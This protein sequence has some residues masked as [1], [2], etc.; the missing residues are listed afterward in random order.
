MA[1]ES[2]QHTSLTE[3]K[4]KWIRVELD[5]GKVLSAEGSQAAEIW[6]WLMAAESILCIHGGHYRGEPF[7]T[8]EPEK[9]R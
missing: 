7:T 1:T 5:N 6:E 3:P 2:K 4:A 9:A 8:T